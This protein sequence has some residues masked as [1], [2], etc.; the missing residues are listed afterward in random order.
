M[1]AELPLDIERALARIDGD[2]PLY[3]DL[4]RLFRKQT[5]RRLAELDEAV[6]T[7]DRETCRRLAHSVRGTAATVAAPGVLHDAE[8]LQAA[9]LAGQP[10]QAALASLHERVAELENFLEES[11][12]V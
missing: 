8:A 5:Q 10:L 6:R 7:D 12:L 3:S 9:V 4:L 1:A 2:Q 11:D